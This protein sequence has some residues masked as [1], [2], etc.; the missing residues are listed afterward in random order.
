V[1][2]RLIVHVDH[3]VIEAAPGADLRRLEAEV[4]AGIAQSF[5]GG[6]A[7]PAFARDAA[8]LQTTH[9]GVAGVGAAIAAAA[10][11]PRRP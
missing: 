5:A 9:A 6:Q 11:P 2:R 1:R 8:V 4:R 10:P 7:P 3:V